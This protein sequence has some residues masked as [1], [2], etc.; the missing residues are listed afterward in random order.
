[1]VKEVKRLEFW[2]QVFIYPTFLLLLWVFSRKERID[3]DGV[4]VRGRE[5][6]T[7]KETGP[8]VKKLLLFVAGPNR[9]GRWESQDWR[10]IKQWPIYNSWI[11]QCITHNKHTTQVR[12][13]KIEKGVTNH[14]QLSPGMS[15]WS[16]GWQKVWDQ[17]EWGVP[18]SSD[19][20][21]SQQCEM[22]SSSKEPAHPSA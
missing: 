10:Y 17:N 14:S 13:V 11:T 4:G 8:D 19:G 6:E 5:R 15:Q 12:A 9:K 7:E 21:I 18:I 20:N 2:F 3:R 16:L 1:M 22:G